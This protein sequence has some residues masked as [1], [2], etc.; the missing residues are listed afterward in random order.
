MAIRDLADP[1]YLARR[2]LRMGIASHAAQLN[3]LL[4]DVG[5]G[6]RPYQ[7]LFPQCRYVGLEV[8]QASV[9][10]SAKH[11]DIL[12]DGRHI[13]I[14]DKMAGSVLC[15][16]VLEHVFAP[17]AFLAEIRR[18]VSPGGKLLLTV[19][20]V[21]DE[22]EQPY[23][24]ARYSSFGLRHLM[25]EAGF[26][27]I[28]HDKTLADASVLVQLWLLSLFKL[29]ARLPKLTRVLIFVLL[30]VPSNLLARVFQALG[31]RN[32]DFYLDNIM[33]CE[34]NEHD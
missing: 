23:D 31:P 16:Q 29:T 22:H 24:F 1:F 34:R 11:A 28:S 32:Q 8:A 19:P 4:V 21:W 17:A 27:I 12:Y 18:I 5:C 26:R 25:E 7:D 15:T 3:G 10:G 20:F 6:T 30:A 13:P 9:H 2:G 33:L 14:P